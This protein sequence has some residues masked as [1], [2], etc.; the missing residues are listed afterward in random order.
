MLRTATNAGKAGRG[1]TTSTLQQIPTDYAEKV[2]WALNLLRRGAG[3]NFPS[4]RRGQMDAFWKKSTFAAVALLS[5]ST[6]ASACEQ[7][8]GLGT[9]AEAISSTKGAAGQMPAF[10]DGHQFTVNM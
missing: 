10:Y 6:F 3:R 1:R 5:I 7:T 8:G 2:L 4:K 9:S